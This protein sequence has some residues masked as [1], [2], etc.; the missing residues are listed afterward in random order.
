MSFLC[1]YLESL[2]VRGA[3]IE[4]VSQRSMSSSLPS[5]PV[6]GAWIEI[7]LS[8][9]PD[10]L[11]TCRS[12]CGERG[13]KLCRTFLFSTRLGRSPCGERGLK[14]W[15]R[16]NGAETICRSPCGER[17]LKYGVSE[18]QVEYATS[19]PVRGAW[20]EIVIAARRCSRIAVA[21]RAGSVD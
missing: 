11:A 21:P 17:G 18:K 20:I 14:S 15:L 7:T 19:L 8:T 5:L 3:W 9:S 16:G 4:M 6:R 2:P 10:A 1:P 13:L 12:P